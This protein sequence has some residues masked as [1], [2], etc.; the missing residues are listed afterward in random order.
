MN[1]S[2]FDRPVASL[3]LVSLTAC[4]SPRQQTHAAAASAPEPPQQAQG[5]DPEP[6]AIAQGEPPV[7]E[8][9][10]T[11][12]TPTEHPSHA[13]PVPQFVNLSTLPALR[14]HSCY[15]VPVRRWSPPPPPYYY[16]KGSGG[17][18]GSGSS[19]GSGYPA[20]KSAPRKAAPSPIM[21]APP[22][23]A[24][25]SRRSAPSDPFSGDLGYDDN[26]QKR[27]EPA[28]APAPPAAAAPPM[29][30]REES[31]GPS[32]GERYAPGPS[33]KR[34]NDGVSDSPKADKAP[35]AR[36]PVASPPAAVPLPEQP[37]AMPPP[38]PPED[39]ARDRYHDWGAK[40][41]LSNDD[42]M[43]LS[44]AQ[45]VIYAIDRFLP[46][47]PDN[48]RPHELLN[49]FSFETAPVTTDNDFSV[50]AELQP[51]PGEPGNYTLGFSVAGRDVS[52]AE[53]RNA[54]LTFVID[55][56]G[57]MSD[58][59]RMNYLKRGLDRMRGELKAGD[60]VNLVLFDDQVC[61][62]VENFVVGRDPMNVLSSAISRLQPRG[63]TDVNLG[64]Q[65][66][67]ALA[68]GS[69]QS[70]HNNRVILITDALANTGE[71]NEDMIAQIGKHYDDRRIRLSG[72][73]VGS[74]FNDT[75]LDK[76]TER[77]K[78]AYLFLGSEAEVD[79]VF[80]ARFNSL[81][82]T[83]ANDVHFRMHLPPSLGMNTFYGEESSTVKEDVQAIHYF[84]GTSQMFLSDVAAR[85]GQVRPSDSVM[86]S[87][88]YENAE[89]GVEQ[90]EEYAFNL[91]EIG[92]RSRNVDKARLIISFID[93]LKDTVGST[94]ERRDYRVAGWIDSYA[95]EQCAQG[96]ASLA[97]QAARLGDD[98][99]VRRVLKLWDSYCSR[100]RS[101]EERP[102]Q[103]VHREA[104]RGADVW[105]SA[106]R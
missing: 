76:L 49:Y 72:I 42:S 18:A 88:E 8:E 12:F 7:V 21:P 65:K 99:E 52:L 30:S 46:I 102:R 75:L 11:V 31:G 74:E 45:R 22:S 105:P 58:E 90:V 86:L 51:K 103:P 87:I 27:A 19:G 79:A 69:Y 81:I 89:T 73:G 24:D 40:I 5:H 26:A 16:G 33:P 84:A 71:T 93:G 23:G 59:G 17:L 41:Y 98:A 100:Y 54:A 29:E 61:V 82:E 96:K 66:G 95:S 67:Y 9:P 53:R 1:K 64:L 3:L 50:E 63:S 36:K 10:P 13:R 4:A 62:P 6:L 77:G 70:T 83:I 57:S 104:P 91:G 15:D 20:P 85:G 32:E 106:Q 37:K 14:T 39:L 92:N 78:G 28:P 97:E 34:G 101:A 43:S 44:S 60:I 35:V 56:S 68:D 94:P 55:R 25:R 2:R 47:A 38:P 80:G 48:I